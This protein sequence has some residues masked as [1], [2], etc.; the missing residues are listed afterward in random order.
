MPD[1]PYFT[2]FP[3]F[4]CFNADVHMKRHRGQRD[5]PCDYCEYRAYTKVDKLRHM[6]VHTG[7]RNQ[8]CQYCGKAF[9]KD[10]TLREHVRSIHERPFKH[11]CSEVSTPSSLGFCGGEISCCDLLHYDTL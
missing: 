3:L 1:T 8:V 7:E 10:S 5:Y 9:A 11:V 4:F 6:T 2:V